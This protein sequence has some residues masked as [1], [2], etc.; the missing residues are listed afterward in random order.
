MATIIP[1]IRGQLGE[2]TYYE[3]TMKVSDLVRSVRG[4]KELDEW[5]GFSIEE[6][7]QRE[8]D[9]KRIKSDLAPYIANSADRFFGSIIVLVYKGTLEWEPI[10]AFAKQL[11]AAYRSGIESMG[12]VTIDGVTLVVLDGQHRLLALRAVQQ[13]DVTGPA[14]A[15]VPNDDVCV[16]F[17]EHQSSIKTR[18]I[19]NVVNRYAKQTGRGDNIITSEDDGYA[20]VARSL[21]ADDAVFGRRKVGA[22]LKDFVEWKSNTL[23]KRSL[24]FTTISA[25]YES[26]K[27][28][29]G[30]S[31]V[32]ALKEQ[33]PS[34]EE[35]ELYAEHAKSFYELL[36]KRIPAYV[37]AAADMTRM[38]DLRAD[39]Q[40]TA[41]IFKPAGQIA[42]IDGIIRAMREAGVQMAI[43]VDRAGKVPDWSM[44]NPLWMGII[45]KSGRT[46]DAGPDAR[47]RMSALIAY[48]IAADKLPVEH[49]LQTWRMYNEAR[50]RGAIDTWEEGG[51]KDAD[52]LEDLPE[53]VA[54]QRFTVDEAR[55][56]LIASGELE[57]AA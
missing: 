7:L 19:F 51:F 17:I 14:A 48:L 1:A 46:I 54:G 27:L 22:D 24:P 30:H 9:T 42:L 34:D 41:L 56:M 3:T 40:P 37:E 28:I 12:F 20:I 25:V 26:V 31:G 6:R 55:R 2:T 5:T 35:L 44:E 15:S 53:P 10:T 23:G 33:R 43:A 16:I 36:M 50:Q 57:E 8:P 49:K 13:G 47:R 11:P 21:L 32:A 45:M 38:P 4:P 18:R 52:G 39:E 29:L